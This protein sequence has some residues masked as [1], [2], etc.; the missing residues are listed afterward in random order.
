M[1]DERLTAPSAAAHQFA[2]DARRLAFIS[3]D[4]AA[5]LIADGETS[6]NVPRNF[7]L[8]DEGDGV[9]VV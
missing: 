7:E 5:G 1:L 2:R 6:A 8:V 9:I 3:T 4:V